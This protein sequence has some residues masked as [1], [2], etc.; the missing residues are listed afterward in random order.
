MTCFLRM[1]LSICSQTHS[2]SFLCNI[3]FP[4]SF[5][6]GNGKHCQ[7][8]KGNRAQVFLLL[9]LLWTPAVLRLLLSSSSCWRAFPLLPA[10]AEQPR[11]QLCP[12]F[13]CLILGCSGLS[14]LLL[15]PGCFTIPVWLV[16]APH[17]LEEETY[18]SFL[19]W[20]EG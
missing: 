11:P 15:L 12:P 16:S 3:H 4:G 13:V 14:L 19:T 8:T 17:T 1:F 10:P 6:K 20:K 18:L 7:E 5:A 2:L 9:S